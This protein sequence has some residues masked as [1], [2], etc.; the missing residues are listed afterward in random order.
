MPLMTISRMISKYCFHC[1]EDLIDVRTGSFVTRT[2]SS[3]VV[4]PLILLWRPIVSLKQWLRL[5]FDDLLLRVYHHRRHRQTWS[6]FFFGH[7]GRNH[8]IHAWNPEKMFNPYPWM[9][10]TITKIMCA[11]RVSVGLSYDANFKWHMPILIKR[12]TWK[13]AK[14]IIFPFGS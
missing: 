3:A 14:L 1:F 10:E 12:W 11:D 5:F 7:L 8:L 2:C 4:H 13:S 9:F 6:Y